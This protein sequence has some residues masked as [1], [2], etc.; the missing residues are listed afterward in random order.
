MEKLVNVTKIYCIVY[1]VA[2][3]YCGLCMKCFIDN[4]GN[5]M[6]VDGPGELFYVHCDVTNEAE[7]KV[8]A[9]LL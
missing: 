6:S 9:L 4:I 5:T 2:D 8:I 7:V 1:A 3:Y